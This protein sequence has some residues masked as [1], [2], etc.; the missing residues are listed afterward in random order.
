MRV[1]VFALAAAA[2]CAPPTEI[3][4][5]AQRVGSLEETI[6]GPHAI[7]RVGD[8]LLQNDQIKLIIADKGPGR[9][10]LPYGGSLVDADLQRLGGP[11]SGNDQLAELLPGFMFVGLD[12]TDVSITNDGTN[13]EPAV[14]TVTGTGDDLLEMIG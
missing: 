1:A 3:Q 7:G 10:N 9:V 13:G 11:E 14:V 5:S 8:F 6:G 4:A 12:P 2:A